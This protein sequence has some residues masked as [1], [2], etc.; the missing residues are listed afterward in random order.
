[1]QWCSPALAFSSLKKYEYDAAT[2]KTSSSWSAISRRGWETVSSVWTRPKPRWLGS[3]Q[4]LTKLDIT[5][6]G[7]LSSYLRVQY[8]ARDLDVSLSAHVA[9]VCRSGYYQLQQLRPALRSQSRSLSM[10]PIV[11]EPRQ[12]KN[13]NIAHPVRKRF[14]TWNRSKDTSGTFLALLY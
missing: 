1:M 7:V 8:T 9:A 5:H 4:Q 13:A 11:R 10:M 6:V 14:D 12:L 2:T 3:H